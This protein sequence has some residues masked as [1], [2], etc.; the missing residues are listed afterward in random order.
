MDK[1]LENAVFC[2]AV[3]AK[4]LKEIPLHPMTGAVNQDSDIF[5]C[6]F[7]ALRKSGFCEAEAVCF[8]KSY[9]IKASVLKSSGLQMAVFENAR[10][11]KTVAVAGTNDFRDVLT[12][13]HLFRAVEHLTQPI[14]KRL[15]EACRVLEG[16][17]MTGVISPDEKFG[18][19]GHSLGGYIAHALSFMTRG[20]NISSLYTF[21]APVPSD[22]G[23]EKFFP[24]AFVSSC[25][26]RNFYAEAGFNATSDLHGFIKKHPE[27]Y[28]MYVPFFVNGTSY[29]M[30]GHFIQKCVESLYVKQFLEDIG[31]RMTNA[32]FNQTAK[33]CCDSAGQGSLEKMVNIIAEELGYTYRLKPGNTSD[34]Y[35][36]TSQIKKDLKGRR[37][38][39]SSVFH[40][41]E[42][43][44]YITPSENPKH[45]A[46]CRAVRRNSPFVLETEGT[47]PALRLAVEEAEQYMKGL[48]ANIRRY[49]RRYRTKKAVL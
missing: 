15:L 8:L 6:D 23:L 31:L 46:F 17:K 20:V 37:L 3:Y 39:L 49:N 32:C 2:K 38:N 24:G 48:K 29:E 33:S 21:N 27:K 42:P 11:R 44:A 35:N 9:K 40:L 7:K 45:C 26:P 25:K 30:D 10:G 14:R 36:F 43:E 28:G 13:F 34:I 19:T 18:L 41:K 22:D 4:N 5:A 12:D 1:A 16:W 47:D